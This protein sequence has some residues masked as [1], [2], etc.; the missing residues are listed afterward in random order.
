MVRRIDAQTWSRRWKSWRCQTRA[1]QDITVNFLPCFVAPGVILFPLNLIS[2]YGSR[3]NFFRSAHDTRKIAPDSDP[4][5]SEGTTNHSRPLNYLTVKHTW[6]SAQARK[7]R[8][9]RWFMRN[10]MTL[11]PMND[12]QNIHDFSTGAQAWPLIDEEH[13]QFIHIFTPRE[14]TNIFPAYKLYFGKRQYRGQCSSAIC[15]SPI[16]VFWGRG[17][18]DEGYIHLAASVLKTINKFR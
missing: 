7:A 18:L 2:A 4:L 9:G 17:L 15:R 16:L 13:P 8:N 6:V 10:N 3:I 12:F 1:R 11:I 5:S 14:R